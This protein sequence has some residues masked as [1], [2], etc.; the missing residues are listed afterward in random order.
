MGQYQ[1]DLDKTRSFGFLG[2]YGLILKIKAF[3]GLRETMVACSNK[4]TA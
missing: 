1:L 3:V 4:N 2:I